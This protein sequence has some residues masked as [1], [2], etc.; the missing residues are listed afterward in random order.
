MPAARFSRPVIITVLKDD[1]G[2]GRARVG[3]VQRVAAA[4]QVAIATPLL[5]LSSMTLDRVRATATDHLGF[6]AETLYAAPLNIDAFENDDAWLTVR[7]A[8]E[9]MAASPGVASV[10]LADGTPLDFRYRITRVATVQ[11]PQL[12][13]DAPKIVA[14][15]VTRVAD[16]FLDTLGIRLLRG[17]AF[18]VE[19]GA[20]AEG[21]ALVSQPLAERLF[22]GE[23]AVGQKLAFNAGEKTERVLTI[24]GVT[25]DFPTSQMSTDRAQVL[26][27]LAQHSSIKYS[28]DVDDDRGGGP[29]LMLIA[30]SAPAEPALKMTAAVETVVRQVDPEFQ[31][32]SVVTGV[33]L[34]KFSVND[35][36]TQSMVAGVVGGV[37]LLLA[38]LG[39][40]GV[41]GLMV[42]TRIREIAVRV[43]LGASRRRVIRMVLVDVVTL[44]TPGVGIGILLAV[45]FVK[46]NGQDF[47]IALSGLEP[48]AYIV[49]SSVAMLIAVAASLAPAR[50][51]A[52]VQPMI[53]MRSE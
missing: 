23:E 37:L 47:G 1:A 31:P 44:V 16:G 9:A 27:P 42:A 39:I 21:V 5:I 4:L 51:A 8:R 3:R 22:A 30:R 2:G 11:D 41:V 48:L 29:R 45:A 50:R 10:T 14:A 26:V 24:V 35:F 38:A 12:G 6:D 28:V 46:L 53:A 40:Y 32:A 19:D 13:S 49:G 43:A 18:G 20:G 25:S 52:S 33:G 36:L 34:R 15:H 7:S 17:R